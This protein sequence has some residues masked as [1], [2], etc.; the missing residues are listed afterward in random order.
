ML[1]RITK[2]L[3]VMALVGTAWL[4]SHAGCDGGG[5][6]TAL[7]GVYDTFGGYY[8]SV[9]SY[10]WADDYYYAD[11]YCCGGGYVYEPYYYDG[12]Y[13]YADVYY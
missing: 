8:D 1:A 7:G 5:M 2:K 10:F 11:P 3:M 9:G 6:Y 12:G 13:G 4:G